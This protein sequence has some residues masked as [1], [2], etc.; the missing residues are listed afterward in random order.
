MSSDPCTE[1]KL[2][3]FLHFHLPM[4]NTSWSGNWLT[5]FRL[6]LC[7]PVKKTNYDRSDFNVTHLKIHQLRYAASIFQTYPR[8]H[9]IRNSVNFKFEDCFH[10]N[11]K[12]KIRTREGSNIWTWMTQSNKKRNIERGNQIERREREKRNLK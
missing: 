2:R 5:L 6:K 12:K 7:L 11:W 10:F 8:L 9:Y 4:D 3:K 1:P